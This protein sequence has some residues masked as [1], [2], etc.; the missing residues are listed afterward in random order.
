MFQF[1]SSY[2]FN[3]VGWVFRV[4]KLQNWKGLPAPISNTR[5]SYFILQKYWNLLLWQFQFFWS[6]LCSSFS[7]NNNRQV[8]NT[9]KWFTATWMTDL[10]KCPSWKIQKCWVNRIIFFKTELNSRANQETPDAGLKHELKRRM[11]NLWLN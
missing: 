1:V 9:W 5:F 8:K 6:C 11:E 10:K 7:H 4:M 2:M 3:K